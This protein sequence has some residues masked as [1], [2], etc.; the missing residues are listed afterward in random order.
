MKRAKKYMAA[1]TAIAMLA[2]STPVDAAAAARLSAR[3]IKMTVGGSKKLTMKNNKKRSR[4][5]SS[6]ADQ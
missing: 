3:S 1:I 5:R 2:S 6:L 4:G